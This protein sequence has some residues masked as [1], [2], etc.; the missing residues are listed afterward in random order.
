M[1]RTVLYGI[2]KLANN[3]A[4]PNSEPVIHKIFIVLNFFRL[5]LC[6]NFQIYI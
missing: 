4:M 5:N 6:H 2:K 3:I 1:L